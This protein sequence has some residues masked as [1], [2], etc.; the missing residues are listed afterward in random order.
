MNGTNVKNKTSSKH[1]NCNSIKKIKKHEWLITIYQK[2]KNV[3]NNIII[4]S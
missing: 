2:P 3:E 4:S 1:L